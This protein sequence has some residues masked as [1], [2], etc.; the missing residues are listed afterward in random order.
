MAESPLTYIDEK[1]GLTW[2]RNANIADK[3]MDWS[4]AMKWVESLNYGGY[5]DWRM[6]TVVE[7]HNFAKHPNR[8]KWFKD[9]GFINVIP[10]GYWTSTDSDNESIQDSDDPGVFMVDMRRPTCMT[11]K[12]DDGYIWPVRGGVKTRCGWTEDSDLTG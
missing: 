10:D 7:L 2:A 1:T 9:N 5:S 11:A 3:Q 12:V 8:F 4:E 6:P